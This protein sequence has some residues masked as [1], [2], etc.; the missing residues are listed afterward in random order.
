MGRLDWVRGA[1]IDLDGV[2]W[3]GETFLPHVQE[4]FG[5]LR[6]NNIRLV[7]ATNNA[8]ASPSAIRQRMKSAGIEIALDEVLTSAMA[9]ASFLEGELEPGARVYAIGAEGLRRALAD[10]GFRVMDASDSVQAVVV[11][12]DREMTWS[13]LAEA[14]LA[15]QAGARFVGT[16]PDVTFPT[17]RG[18][19]PGNG[20]TLAALQAATGVD[21]LV[22]GKPE[23]YL[24]QQA[25]KQL[26]VPVDSILVVGDRLGTDIEGGLRIGAKTML[27][28]TGVTD[29]A[30]AES[31]TIQAD[32]ICDDLATAV[33][34]LQGQPS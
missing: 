19:V 17:E 20:A 2:I 3:R 32:Y 5:A 29:R 15:I 24:Y 28:L 27:L 13:Q 33:A 30:M 34:W 14:C 31:S 22:I 7:L 11:G 25:M 23:P 21:P 12:M 1:I 6:Q 8:T 26:A 10:H 9:T 18:K 4:F 16:N